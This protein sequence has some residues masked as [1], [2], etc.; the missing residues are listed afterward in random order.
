MA[1]G[2][3]QRVWFPDMIEKLR[4][5]WRPGMS[6]E[7]LI[8]LRDVLDAMLGR[9][10]STGGIRTPI[11]SCQCCG[12][13]GPGAEPKVSVRAMILSLA[14]FG[15]ADPAEMKILERGWAN[16]RKQ[17]QVDLYGKI[18]TNESGADH[19]GNPNVR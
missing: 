16:Y 13:T 8:E 7:S 4:A 15:I 11:I 17:N 6:F 3:P 10:R 12:Y 18:A 9:I 19:C 14:R 2:D 5:E 1:A